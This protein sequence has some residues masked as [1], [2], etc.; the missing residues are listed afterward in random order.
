MILNA[1]EST[2]MSPFDDVSSLP[3]EVKDTLRRGLKTESLIG[4]TVAR[5]F[6]SAIVHLIGG[7]RDALKL[8]Q[9]HILIFSKL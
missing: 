3:S 2:I 1:D 8:R 4:D 6:L 5:A 9:V 7:Y